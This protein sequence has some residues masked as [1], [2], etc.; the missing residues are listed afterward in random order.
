ML[1]NSN[2]T[3]I[4]DLTYEILNMKRIQCELSKPEVMRKYLNE[5]EAHI[6]QRSMTQV[7]ELSTL[8][9]QEYNSLL[10]SVKQNPEQWILKPNREGG[11]NNMFGASLIP[12]LESLSIEERK[13]YILHEKIDS[14]FYD[15]YSIN[16]DQILTKIKCDYE[17]GK[18]TVTSVI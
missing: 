14:K 3:C 12:V 10:I 6:L 16:S 4:P 18:F 8:S 2:T 11:G 5:E 1:A 7:K 13:G 9:E 15:N 17:L